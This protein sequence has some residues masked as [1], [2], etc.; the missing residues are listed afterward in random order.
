[1]IHGLRNHRRRGRWRAIDSGAQA[2]GQ[3]EHGGQ[4]CSHRCLFFHRGIYALG[5]PKNT[6]IRKEGISEAICGKGR[7][8]KGRSLSVPPRHAVYST[9]E[10]L[11]NDRATDVRCKNFTLDYSSGCC[12][13]WVLQ[14]FSRWW[15]RLHSDAVDGLRAG[16]T[17]SSR[18]GNRSF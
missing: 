1:A 5:K 15:R 4:L 10:D 17:Y 12:C 3:R 13:R 16:N 2:R 6:E 18:S 9:A 14:W 8:I 11:A 7:T